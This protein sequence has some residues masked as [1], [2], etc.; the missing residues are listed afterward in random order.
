M[1]SAGEIIRVVVSWLVDNQDVVQMVFHYIMESGSDQDAN[2]VLDDIIAAQTTAWNAHLDDEVADNVQGTIAE[3]YK[4]DS[5]QNRFD[6]LDSV[7][8]SMDGIS[9]NVMLPQGVAGLV[10]FYT[11]VGRYRGRKYVP[12]LTTLRVG[13]D[14]TF[15]SGLATDLAFWGLEVD[16]PVVSGGVSFTPGVFNTAAERFTRFSGTVESSP[17]PAYQRRRREGVGI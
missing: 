4:W 5:G 13:S 9:G 8:H 2:D 17:I 6:G 12:G 11:G 7:P 14:G 10:K 15:T 3:L 1:I 16:D